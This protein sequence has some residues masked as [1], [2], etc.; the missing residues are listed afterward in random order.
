MRSS[1]SSTRCRITD[2][3]KRFWLWDGA[4][5]RT[6]AWYVEG[7]QFHPHTT[8]TKKKDSALIAT[9]PPFSETEESDAVQ[10]RKNSKSFKAQGTSRNLQALSSQRLL[11]GPWSGNKPK[12]SPV[13]EF[14]SGPSLCLHKWEDAFYFLCWCC[15]LVF[16]GGKFRFLDPVVRK[17]LL[18]SMQASY[19][20]KK[21][22]YM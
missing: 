13:L 8:T 2:Y 18:Y 20:V 16:P 5:H 3:L 4:Q 17:K 10:M 22:K 6:L 15:T 19:V 12:A 1:W 11:E 14:S 21:H 7:P 9:P